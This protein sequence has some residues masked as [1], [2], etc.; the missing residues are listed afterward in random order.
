MGA[1]RT[2][3]GPAF[4]E[5]NR[6]YSEQNGKSKGPESDV[7]FKHGTR[8]YTDHESHYRNEGDASPL[9]YRGTIR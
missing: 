1:K 3:R 9:L 7:E 4:A 6:N 2:R 8:Y 5:R